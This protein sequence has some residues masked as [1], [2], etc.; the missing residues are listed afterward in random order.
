MCDFGLVS[1]QW[2]CT[3]LL[4]DKLAIGKSSRVHAMT[5]VGGEKPLALLRSFHFRSVSGVRNA[6]AFAQG[7]LRN[8]SKYPKFVPCLFI[9][10]AE[11]SAKI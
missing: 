5:H 1:K 11:Q 10:M 2:P 7:W 9:S 4:G 8:C 6:Q 3:P